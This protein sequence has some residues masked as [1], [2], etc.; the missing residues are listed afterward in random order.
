MK[1]TRESVFRCFGDISP[2]YILEAAPDAYPAV[3][4]GRTSRSTDRKRHT[5]ASFMRSGWGVAAVCILCGGLAYALLLS[6]GNG[7]FPGISPSGHPTKS[8]T[9][10]PEPV[11]EAP[12]ETVQ[13][14]ET[15][16]TG[17]PEN[18][19]PA[20]S[21]DG[22]TDHLGSL[23]LGGATVSILTASC[24]G[25]ESDLCSERSYQYINAA[26]TERDMIVEKRLNCHIATTC[27]KISDRAM[28]SQHVPQI[29]I[30]SAQNGLDFEFDIYCAP[31]QAM[32]LNTIIYGIGYDLSTI[33]TV[34]LSRLYWSSSFNEATAWDNGQDGHQYTA[35][36]SGSINLL[37]SM[38]LLVYNQTAMTEIGADPVDMVRNGTWTI[39]SML[40]LVGNYYSDLNGNNKRDVADGYGFLTGRLRSVAHWAPATRTSAVYHDDE[41]YLAL[42]R[43]KATDAKTLAAKVRALYEATGTYAADASKDKIQDTDFS[44]DIA[45]QFGSGRACMASASLFSVENGLYETQVNYGILPL[46]KLNVQDEYATP[47]LKDI[48]YSYVIP[49]SLSTEAARKAGAV[50]ECM[51]SEGTRLLLPAYCQDILSS[52]AFGN[53]QALEMLSVLYN[54]VY[55]D[56]GELYGVGTL[57]AYLLNRVLDDSDAYGSIGALLNEAGNLSVERYLTQFNET[58][59]E[60]MK[61]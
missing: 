4:P 8:E 21:G 24:S 61:N 29:M 13:G 45:V 7:H 39:D 19:A 41:G 31:V 18:P 40:G 5:F 1:C 60:K 48:A 6:L 46:P 32:A 50:L 51:A 53:S 38:A 2:E 11:P 56:P 14:T 25:E 47:I 27:E 16:V 17:T 22:W 37:R 42:D 58:Y 57:D 12:T 15:A 49:S 54:G 20:F 3:S 36:G 59:K 33:S 28:L 23:D 9:T 55:V 10:V 44:T 30:L 43:S 35:T 26:L 34:D 52:E